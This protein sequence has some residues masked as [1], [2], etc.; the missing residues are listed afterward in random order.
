[1]LATMSERTETSRRS[2]LDGFPEASAS[3]DPLVAKALAA[4]RKE[5]ARRWTVADLGRVAGLSRAAL[6]RRFSASVGVPPLAWLTLYR[7]GMAQQHLM[8]DDT[9]LAAVAAQVGYA[10]EFAF[11]KAFKRAF[12]VPPGQFRRLAR[13]RG[14]NPPTAFRAAA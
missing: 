11:A 4:M 13:Q 7:L 3:S 12:G 1:M 2:A 8:Q 10:S 14:A 9:G 6:A 5:P